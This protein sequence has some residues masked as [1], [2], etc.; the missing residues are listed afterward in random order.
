[1]YE[2]GIWHE[3]KVGMGNDIKKGSETGELR[4]IIF[5]LFL[6]LKF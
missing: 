4:H 1:M 6:K 3:D 2:G 5:C